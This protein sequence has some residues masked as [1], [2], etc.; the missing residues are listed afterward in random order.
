MGQCA[1]RPRELS[2]AGT[3]RDRAGTGTGSDCGEDG[4]ASGVRAVL[5]A[6]C[7]RLEAGGCTGLAACH[8]ACEGRGGAAVTWAAVLADL[9]DAALLS[10]VDCPGCQVR[11]CSMVRTL[12][13]SWVGLSP[14]TPGHDRDWN[15][16]PHMLGREQG[17]TPS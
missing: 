2:G 10:P 1:A 3:S 8:T 7:D 12:G 5:W 14:H 16:Q 9:P 17:W 4:A 15:F 11:L 13:G 6:T